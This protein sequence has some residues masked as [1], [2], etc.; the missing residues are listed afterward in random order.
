MLSTA[1]YAAQ[2]NVIARCW[3][4]TECL[5]C[6]R[7]PRGPPGFIEI[8]TISAGIVFS[9]SS[10]PEEGC[11]FSSNVFYMNHRRT[12]EVVR[13]GEP[14]DQLHPRWL[15]FKGARDRSLWR[16]RRAPPI[17]NTGAERLGDKGPWA[18]R[19]NPVPRATSCPGAGTGVIPRH[20]AQYGRFRQR[21]P[22]PRG[23]RR[24]RLPDAGTAI[25]P[26]AGPAGS[27]R[28][29]ASRPPSRPPLDLRRA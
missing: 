3:L 21:R 2:F 26:A 29:P 28:R 8:C 25:R 12:G 10:Q 11:A 22:R 13:V 15:G 5:R 17:G 24:H 6:M 20:P 14:G 16:R 9:D 23:G 4:R 1:V 18:G 27:R 19:D 7:C